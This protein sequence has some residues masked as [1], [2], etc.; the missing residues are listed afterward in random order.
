MQQRVQTATNRPNTKWEN[1]GRNNILSNAATSAHTGAGFATINPERRQG[2]S[3]IPKEKPLSLGF[4]ADARQR[5]LS[6]VNIEAKHV[7][8]LTRPVTQGR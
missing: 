3:P 8:P 7:I 4:L 2:M 5:E 6:G 1:A